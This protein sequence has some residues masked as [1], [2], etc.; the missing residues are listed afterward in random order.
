MLDGNRLRFVRLTGERLLSSDVELARR[1]CDSEASLI[2]AYGLTEANGIVSQKVLPLREAEPRSSLD[3]GRP[4]DGVE[5]WIEGDSGTPLATGVEG[6]IIVGGE[7]LSA[8]YLGSQERRAGTRF[9]RRGQ[10]LVLH[11]GDRGV[12]HADGSLEVRGR[13]DRRLKV[14]GQRVDPS[15]VEAAA[16]RH[17]GVL[18]AAV[19][20]FSPASGDTAMALFAAPDPNGDP[21]ASRSLQ[22]HTEEMVAP[23]A[24]PAITKVVDELP[25]TSAGKVDLLRLTQLAE[26]GDRRLPPGRGRTDPLVRHLVRLW[27]EALEIDE[28]APDEDFFALGADS[29]ASAEVCAAIEVT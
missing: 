18:D 14:R 7:F 8:G 27:Q 23:E 16:L 17:D 22:A 3:S 9:A 10:A 21:V 26:N 6:E 12:L 4:L 15:E 24:I 29:L 11:T 25:R 2:T 5:V 1:I 13:D 28:P 19:V 20:P